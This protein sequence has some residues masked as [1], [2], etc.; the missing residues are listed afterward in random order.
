MMKRWWILWLLILLVVGCG[1]GAEETP[2]AVVA[3]TV[4]PSPSATLTVTAT[5]IPSPTPIPSTSTPTKTITPSPTLTWQIASST[6]HY[7]VSGNALLWHPDQSTSFRI[8]G[9]HFSKHPWSPDGKRLVGVDYDLEHLAILTLLTGEVERLNV[10]GM[11]IN[12][13][14]WSPDGRFLLFSRVFEE[15]LN[16][17][18]I[19]IYDLAAK[20]ITYESSAI[21]LVEISGWS[22]DSN[23]VAYLYNKLSETE[24]SEQDAVLEILDITSLEISRFENGVDTNY[25]IQAS[26]SPLAYQLILYNIPWQPLYPAIGD[27]VIYHQVDLLDVGTGQ[28]DAIKRIVGIPE[29]TFPN[30]LFISQNPWSSDGKRIVYTD[31]NQICYLD[32]MSRQERCPSE[33]NELIYEAGALRG[34]YPSWSP[35]GEWISFVLDLPERQGG[36]MAVIRPDGSELR[37]VTEGIVLL[38][39]IWSP[40]GS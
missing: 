37:Q 17:S 38:G 10:S 24:A 8:N 33:V 30:W 18:Q 13:A 39:F 36:Y 20:E 32:I 21:D 15:D 6:N 7:M 5:T 27:N 22:F 25:W 9:Y 3:V 28:L 1:D 14:Q 16:L 26:W 40:A 29:E 19:I 12:P 31:V 35:D 11:Y 34:A 2:T 4:A 23:Y